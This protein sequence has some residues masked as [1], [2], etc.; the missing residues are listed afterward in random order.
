MNPMQDGSKDKV[1]QDEDQDDAKSSE[2]FESHASFQDN[3]EDSDVDEAMVEQRREK[4]LKK[5][6]GHGIKSYKLKSNF[7]RI[8]LIVVAIV[9]IPLQIFLETILQ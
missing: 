2:S 8:L 4:V 6:F 7:L 9:L 5:R 1:D 3:L